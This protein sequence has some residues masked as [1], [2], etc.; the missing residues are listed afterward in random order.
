MTSPTNQPLAHRRFK[1]LRRPPESIRPASPRPQRRD[2]QGQL[3]AALDGLTG[4]TGAVEQAT[5]RPW[6]SATFVGAQHHI[7]LRITG[8]N[9]A[10]Q[11]ETLST[12]LGEA[13]FKLRGHI[14]ADLAVD[15]V[16]P[17]ENGDVTITLVVLTIEDW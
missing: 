5:L 16:R 14:V 11:A 13:D 12:S 17:E 9:A 2:C 10:Q 1:L 15:E 6:C 4:E 3:L 8:E 7:M